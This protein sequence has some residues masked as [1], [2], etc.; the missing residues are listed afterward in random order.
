[1][2]EPGR[3]FATA[4]PVESPVHPCA[5]VPMGLGLAIPMQSGPVSVG[6]N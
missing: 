4:R 5:F 6:Q 3:K 2:F 1:M